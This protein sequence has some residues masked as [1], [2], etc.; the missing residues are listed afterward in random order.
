MK[1]CPHCEARHKGTLRTCPICMQDACTSPAG[2]CSKCG[3]PLNKRSGCRKGTALP[4]PDNRRIWSC[5][6][7]MQK[8]IV[9]ETE[10]TMLAALRRYLERDITVNGP[11]GTGNL[12]PFTG[13]PRDIDTP[14]P[15]AGTL[16][17]FLDLGTKLRN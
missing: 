4:D 3:K 8:A 13:A 7:V 15:V 2:T 1:T 9:Y 16:S 10:A 5:E 6:K 17:K 12:C 14:L 11:T